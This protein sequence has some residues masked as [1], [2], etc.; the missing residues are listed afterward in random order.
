[1]Q[2]RTRQ[3]VDLLTPRGLRNDCLC[4]CYRIPYKCPYACTASP[5]LK[6]KRVHC[7]ECQLYIYIYMYG[8]PPKDLGSHILI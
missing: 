2:W 8:T 4:P 7:Q 1:M 3:L 5:L 6:R